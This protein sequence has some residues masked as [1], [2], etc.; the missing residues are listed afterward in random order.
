[1]GRTLT[2]EPDKDQE[3]G[4]L[5]LLYLQ[6]HPDASDTLEGIAEWW[7]LHKWTAL[8]LAEVERAVD[9]LLSEHLLLESHPTG[10]SPLYRLNEHKKRAISRILEDE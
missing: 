5:I 9:Y 4:R 8:R 2:K 3:I 10:S 6:D 7:V 1:M